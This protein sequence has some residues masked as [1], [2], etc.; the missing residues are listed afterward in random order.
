MKYPKRKHPGRASAGALRLQT[1][2]D[3]LQGKFTTG[4]VTDAMLAR[5]LGVRRSRV[6]QLITKGDIPPPNRDNGI[7]LSW[8]APRFTR[9]T[10]DL[11]AGKVVL[12]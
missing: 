10:R 6:W 8:S 5:Y 4:P 3:R 9:L 2:G 1:F 11:A 7:T 12:S